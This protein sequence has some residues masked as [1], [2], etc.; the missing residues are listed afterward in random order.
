MKRAYA[1]IPEGQVH[2]VTEGEGKPLLLLHMTPRS[3][4]IYRNVIPL[5]SKSRRVIAMDSLGF[6][7]SDPPPRA[8]FAIPDYAQS[9][10]HFLDALGIQNTD[11]WGSM[12]GSRIAA[13]FAATWPDRVRRL[14]LLGFPIFYTAEERATRIAEAKRQAMGVPQADGSH[15]TKMWRY[16]V[17]GDPSKEVKGELS[18][19]EWE[20][21]TNWI[22]DAVK[23]GSRWTDA[24]TGVVYGHDP[25][26]ALGRIQAPT[27][28][29]GLSSDRNGWYI[30]GER[31]KKVQE[32]I[33]NSR[34]VMLE[35]PDTD[36][37][38]FYL[39]A[40]QLA[41]TVM[42]FLE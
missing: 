3:W 37:R 35:G 36:S 40:K 31:A 7:N 2:Y 39:R 13:E 12:T 29:F 4:T 23:A 9:V 32:L 30:R 41:D 33:P 17:S 11:I 19:V 1:D 34:L 24:A 26:P 6:G 28:V 15:L 20:I 42:Q 38:V 5:L 22:V 21:V 16:F 10:A 27:L 18:E 14:V 25:T 8:N